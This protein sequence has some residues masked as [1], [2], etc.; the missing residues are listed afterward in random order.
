M[1]VGV[2]LTLLDGVWLICDTVELAVVIGKQAKN[3][4]ATDAEAHIAGYG[5]FIPTHA[6]S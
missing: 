2:M 1:K 6:P 3:I 4:N 5:T